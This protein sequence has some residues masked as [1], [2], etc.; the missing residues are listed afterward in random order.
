LKRFF[1]IFEIYSDRRNFWKL[2]RT[3][4]SLA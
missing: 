1:T 3:K 4:S 2:L